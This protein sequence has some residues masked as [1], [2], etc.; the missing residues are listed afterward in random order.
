M[1][2]DKTLRFRASDELIARVDE[3]VAQTPGQNRSAVLRALVHA[4]LGDG[5]GTAAVMQA[6]YDY[7]GVRKI[8]FRRLT[9]QMSEVLPLIVEEALANEHHADAG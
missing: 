5:P 2:R 8:I 7:S 4:A 9:E 1:A 3:L 6:I